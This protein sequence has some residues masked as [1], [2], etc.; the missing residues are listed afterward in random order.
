MRTHRALIV[1]FAIATLAA[2]CG[3][4]EVS[5]PASTSARVIND[6]TFGSERMNI[7]AVSVNLPP[8]TTFQQSEFTLAYSSTERS[9]SANCCVS[10]KIGDRLVDAQETARL[11]SSCTKARPP[12]A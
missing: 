5:S 8:R 2:G 10:L 3:T 12:A 7:V 1:F 11:Q 4:R 6:V 9:S